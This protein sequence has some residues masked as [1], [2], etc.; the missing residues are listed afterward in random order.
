MKR[1]K[2]WLLSAGRV[3]V[4]TSLLLLFVY[5]LLR[6][7]YSHPET[8]AIALW[9]SRFDPFLVPLEMHALL[10]VPDWIWLPLVLLLLTAWFGRVFCGWFCPL[11]ALLNL[12]YYLKQ[13]LHIHNHSELAT[14][15]EKWRLW[16]LGGF[17][18]AVSA[19]GAVAFLFT[20]FALLSHEITRLSSGQV[21]WLLLGL[22]LSG[23]LFFPRFWCVSFCPT[24]LLMAEF[25]RFRKLKPALGEAC[26]H[27]GHCVSECPSQTMDSQTGAASEACLSCG[28]CSDGC[29]QKAITWQHIA[30]SVT[31]QHKP[32]P[33]RRRLFKLGTALAIGSL[34][35]VG[36]HKY[37]WRTG[38]ARMLRPPGSLPENDFL[39]TCNRCSRCIKVCPTKGLHAAPLAEGI[40]AYG[41]PELIPRKGACELCMMCARICPTGAIQPVAPL[42]IKIGIALLNE[43][44]CLA[45][46]QNKDCL[47][48]KERCPANAISID[49][50]KR[51][52]I[53]HERCIGCG[54]CE[55]ACPVENSAVIVLP[56]Y[57]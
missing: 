44:T 55:N 37:F 36:T 48:C 54:A 52:Y 32:S 2:N 29:P 8:A 43:S 4:P 13:F 49:T 28:R 53:D 39:T 10:A 46:S 17:I 56:R 21:P 12:M 26:V 47:I 38:E 57:D 24:G 51:P 15:L 30:S 33:S 18:L 31:N 34:I 6:T 45:W 3:I 20:P 40:L 9:M 41:S 14:R 19:V 16:L 7:S 11:G 23:F 25:S 35:E 1:Q 22:L 50:Y 42:D 5:S 27:C